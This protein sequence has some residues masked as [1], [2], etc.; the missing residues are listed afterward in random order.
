VSPAAWLYNETFAGMRAHLRRVSDAGWVIDLSPEGMKPKVS[1]RVFPGVQ[2]P[3]SAAVFVGW[4]Q[5]DHSQPAKVW[6]STLEGTRDEKLA[7]LEALVARLVGTGPRTEDREQGTDPERPAL[8]A[9]GGG[10]A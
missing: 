5:V 4:G 1:N 9:A 10:G 2:I 6:R 8:A 3:L 7:G